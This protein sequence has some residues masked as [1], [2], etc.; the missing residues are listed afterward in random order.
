MQHFPTIRAI[1]SGGSGTF[2]GNDCRKVQTEGK[3][4][5]RAGWQCG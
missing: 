4:R 2:L 5:N 1:I 3:L